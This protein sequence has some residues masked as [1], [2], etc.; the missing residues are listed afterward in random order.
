VRETNEKCPRKK[1]KGKT[2]TFSVKKGGKTGGEMGP[3]VER[4]IFGAN[5]KIEGSN[6]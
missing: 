2:N 4:R 6:W 1:K 5:E 3:E